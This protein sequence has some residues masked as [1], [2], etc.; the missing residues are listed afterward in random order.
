MGANSIVINTKEK[1]KAKQEDLLPGSQL[2]IWRPIHYLGSKLRLVDTIRETLLQI[3]PAEG[4]VCDLFAGSGTVSL[5]LSETRDV[6]AVDI[7]EYSRT[8]CSALLNPYP[9]DSLNIFN[10]LNDAQLKHTTERLLWAM[11]PMI[12]HEANCLKAAGNEDPNPICNLIEKGCIYA[13]EKKG[14]E[15]EDKAL[16]KSLKETSNRL[17]KLESTENISTLVSRY[18]GGLYFSYT[19]AAQIDALLYFISLEG[20]KSKKD[21]LLAAVL[22]TASDL[23]NTVGKQFAQPIRPR[24]KSGNPK[25]HLIRQIQRDRNKSSFELFENWLCRYG[26]LVPT[27]NSHQAVCNDYYDFLQTYKGDLSVVYADPPYTRDHY[28]RFYH[29]LETICLRDNPDVSY[30]RVKGQDLLSRGIYRENRHQSPFCIKSQAPEA[31]DKLFASV[32]TFDASLLLS[33][34]PYSVDAQ[35]RPRVMKVESIEEIAKEY[36]KSVEIVSAGR[37]SHNKLNNASLSKEVSYDA[38]LFLICRP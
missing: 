2:A 15:I 24:D 14:C 10:I 12:S 30:M 21:V 5:A 18:F 17:A 33:Y 29:V 19:Q 8:I 38:E 13:F 20:Q 11:E 23:V 6:T 25:R 27:Q 34:S 22:S 35:G 16:I 26:S 9:F 36:F 32:K 3:D 7:Q 4:P 31:F 37:I 1:A 28:S